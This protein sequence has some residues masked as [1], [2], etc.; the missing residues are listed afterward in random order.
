M[1]LSS[2][3][4]ARSNP[5][6]SFV[7]SPMRWIAP[8]AS[9]MT[10]SSVLTRKSRASASVAFGC[11]A[12]KSFTVAGMS[13]TSFLQIAS[14]AAIALLFSTSGAGCAF[15]VSLPHAAARKRA[16]H[17]SIEILR[18]TREGYRPEGSRVG[19]GYRSRDLGEEVV[20]LVVNDDERGEVHDLDL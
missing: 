5:F 14:L 11:F 8:S 9:S 12:L 15:P 1:S 16:P 2:A 6:R 20:A 17:A 3:V 4:T 19:D 10:G 7:G 13:A 18:R